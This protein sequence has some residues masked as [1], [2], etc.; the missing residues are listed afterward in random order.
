MK[1]QK[2]GN[3]VEHNG[4]SDSGEFTIEANASAFQILSSG[5]YTNKL[6]APIRELACNAFDA[7]AASGNTS[8]PIEITLPSSKDSNFTVKDFGPGLTKTEVQSIYTTYF[9][10]TRNDS[11]DYT[12]GFGIGSKSPFA[13]VE[14]FHIQSRHNGE[15]T[16]YEAFLDENKLPRIKEIHSAATV[17][18]NGLTVTLKVPKDVI[19]AFCEEAKYVFMAFSSPYTAVRDKKTFVVQSL[20]SNNDLKKRGNTYWPTRHHYHT[21]PVIVMGNIEYP[22]NAAIQKMEIEQEPLLEWFLRKNVIIDIP[23]GQLSV[24]ASREDLSYDRKTLKN[25]KNIITTE[26]KTLAESIYEE[27]KQKASSKYEAATRLRQACIELGL[28]EDT[29]VIEKM[30]EL[31]NWDPAIIGVVKDGVKS[32]F[33][34]G[35]RFAAVHPMLAEYSHKLDYMMHEHSRHSRNKS[36]KKDYHHNSPLEVITDFIHELKGLSSHRG[37]K[38][39]YEDMFHRFHPA[40]LEMILHPLEP[41][42]PRYMHDI[43]NFAVVPTPHIHDLIREE[44]YSG[45]S[46]I[47]YL[48]QPRFDTLPD[49]NLIQ[50]LLMSLDKVRMTPSLPKIKN[51]ENSY[52]SERDSMGIIYPEESVTY[53]QFINILNE[54]NKTWGTSFDTSATEISMSDIHPKEKKEAPIYVQEV[55]SLEDSNSRRHRSLWDEEPTDIKDL[56][57]DYLYTTDRHVA[58]FFERSLGVNV[59]FKELG[60]PPSVILIHKDDLAKVQS[61]GLPSGRSLEDFVK[62]EVHAWA[63]QNGLHRELSKRHGYHDENDPIVLETLL[64]NISQDAVGAQLPLIQNFKFSEQKVFDYAS[65]STA[66]GLLDQ[67]GITLPS[68]KDAH[69]DVKDAYPFLTLSSLQNNIQAA[70]NYIKAI[71]MARGNDIR[72]SNGLGI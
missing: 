34:D 12:G 11:N 44:G 69:K 59:L 57:G 28:K 24:A 30:G 1:L 67:F 5:V 29:G 32:I 71:D 14:S 52:Y 47:G 22:L 41:Y 26:L 53:E 33:P 15:A 4:L 36:L 7:H 27:A 70:I 23:V 35:V 43:S 37:G 63:R 18:P 45:R 72:P 61:R 3:E 65:A 51:I 49:E 8:V 64:K 66:V 10:S 50:A 19:N 17:E 60:A 58:Y 48:R 21:S 9:K 38:L 39:G 20:T 62:N 56:G 42:N 6:R 16:L 2:N 46:M 13:V 54:V 31:G 68:K 55:L 25:L 40:M